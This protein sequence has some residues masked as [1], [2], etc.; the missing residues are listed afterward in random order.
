[1]Y[2]YLL[3]FIIYYVLFVITRICVM[4]VGQRWQESQR[5]YQIEWSEIFRDFDGLYIYK[6]FRLLQEP[7]KSPD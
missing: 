4:T 1:M 5:A 6:L 7:V 2:Y 3:I